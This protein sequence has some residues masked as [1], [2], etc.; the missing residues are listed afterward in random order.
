MS[1][2]TS[3]VASDN[4]RTVTMTAVP[5][6]SHETCAC[7]CS[8]LLWVK[9]LPESPAARELL[10]TAEQPPLAEELHLIVESPVARELR[11][12][13]EQPPL[14][15]E[16]HLI[17]ESPVARELLLA[18]EQ[19]PLAEELYLIAESPVARELLSA[20]EQGS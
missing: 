1:P 14:A 8:M 5:V 10:L 6:V 20:A 17:A 2:R 19:P 13:A 7:F 3:A 12:A 18:A 16:P 11:L 4:S 15:E 9:R